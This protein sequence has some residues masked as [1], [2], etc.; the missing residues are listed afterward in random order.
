MS[1]GTKG[2]GWFARVGRFFR[3]RGLAILAFI[4]G[5]GCL[6]VTVAMN[7]FGGASMG[8]DAQAQALLGGAGV[9]VEIVGI[10]ILGLIGPTLCHGKRWYWRAGLTL[11]IMLSAGYCIWSLWDFMSVQRLSVEAARKAQITARDEQ[12]QLKVDAFKDRQRSDEQARKEQRDLQARLAQEQLRWLQRDVQGAGR[13]E[14]KELR[15][16]TLQGA[17]DIIAKVGQ[18]EAPPAAASPDMPS[19]DASDVIVRPDLGNESMAKLIG[20]EADSLLA[21]RMAYLAIVLIM[22]ESIL[23]PATGNLWRRRNEVVDLI[24]IPLTDYAQARPVLAEAA[25]V[26]LALAGPVAAPSIVSTETASPTPQLPANIE[27]P[28]PGGEAGASPAPEPTPPKPNLFLD[29]SPLPGAV[30][31]LLAIGFPVDGRPAGPQRPQDVP[32]TAA[33]R[34]V[35]V[36]KA[37]GRDGK[38]WSQDLEALYE[39]FC[40][41]DHREMTSVKAVWLALQK[42]PG[43]EQKDERFERG[44]DKKRSRYTITPGKYPRKPADAAAPQEVG[45]GERAPF[46]VALPVAANDTAPLPVQKQS[47]PHLATMPK[48]TPFLA[49]QERWTIV[50]EAAEARRLKAELRGQSR[51]QRGSRTHRFA[52]AA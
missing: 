8:A 15:K 26:P 2:P 27:K 39:Q 34:F 45:D 46:S 35:R 22:L 30:R 37:F 13:K 3:G 52:R 49:E 7:M 50:A 14:R 19:L 32:A 47:R 43:I 41:A 11:T 18:G 9:A 5:V 28:M 38:H 29:Q 51:K 48:R 17:A 25:P 40:Q 31:E 21:I 36:M 1:A 44:S 12:K 20:M 6:Y 16:E 4:G 10:C 24:P 23:F 33:L 42:T